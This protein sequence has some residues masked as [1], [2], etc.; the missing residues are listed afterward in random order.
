V[1]YG[2]WDKVVDYF[3]IFFF[4]DSKVSK[5]W[6]IRF[7]FSFLFLFF[8]VNLWWFLLEH[9][10]YKGVKNVILLYFFESKK[11][12][13][14]GVPWC[15]KCKVCIFIFICSKHDRSYA[16]MQ[17]M[18]CMIMQTNIFIWQFFLSKRKWIWAWNEKW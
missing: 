16:K 7:F 10:F 11:W 14:M 17:T 2:R 4:K 13:C 18:T 8:K 1:D 6:V 9:E 15:I 12:T 5:I 3:T